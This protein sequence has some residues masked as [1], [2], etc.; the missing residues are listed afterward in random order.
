MRQEIHTGATRESGIRLER[1]GAIVILT[2]A[3]PA[4]L[5]ALS[6][7]VYRGL[8]YALDLLDLDAEM[9]A[10][11]I[12]GAPRLDGRA[13]FCSGADLWDPELEQGSRLAKEAFGRIESTAKPAIAAVGGLA[14]GGGLELA[15]ACD[16]RVAAQGTRLGFPEV[17]IGTMPRAGGTQ[18]LPRLIGVGR[19]KQLLLLG[20]YIDGS[21]AYDIGLVDY[22]TPD[23]TELGRAMDLARQ[24]AQKAPLAVAAIKRA[25]N[26]SHDLELDDGLDLEIALGE[27][28]D[29]TEDRLE[30]RRAFIEKRTP[31]YRGK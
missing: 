2:L 3:R 28:L 27:E 19:A 23:G 1:D 26:S 11:V 24:L 30:G 20:E 7:A 5:N 25:V 13:C 17:N 16:F 22:V 18:R 21:R 6:G 31:I 12:T 29:R 9:R 14:L 4:V 15:M 8:I 10:L